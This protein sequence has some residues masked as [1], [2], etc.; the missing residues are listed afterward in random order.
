M[1]T[2]VRERKER[3]RERGRRERGRRERGTKRERERSYDKVLK[4]LH[5]FGMIVVA[6]A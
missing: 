5:G 1:C 3:H 6:R 2:H 4:R